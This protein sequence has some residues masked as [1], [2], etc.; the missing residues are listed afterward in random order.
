ML[1]VPLG[2]TR[3]F[4]LI[5]HRDGGQIPETIHRFVMRIYL[6]IK[7]PTIYIHIQRLCCIYTNT[8]V[9]YTRVRLIYTPFAGNRTIRLNKN[10]HQIA[11]RCNLLSS[12]FVL[13][14]TAII[15]V[16]CNMGAKEKHFSK[17]IDFDRFE[18]VQM[19][20]GWVFDHVYLCWLGILW[21]YQ[22]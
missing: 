6:I 14:Y 2:F 13:L 18:K 16:S 20:Q 7:E 12:L 3:L 15:V 9:Y 10:L 11:H 19:L 1:P 17:Q 5:Q 8:N 4:S 21:N 22:N